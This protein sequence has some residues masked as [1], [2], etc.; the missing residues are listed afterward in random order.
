[1]KIVKKNILCSIGAILYYLFLK[2]LYLNYIHKF[3]DYSGFLYEGRQINPIISILLLLPAILFLSHASKKKEVSY[4]VVTVLIIIGFFPALVMA[5]FMRTEFFILLLVY[6]YFLMI[7]TV[8]IKTIRFKS[9]KFSGR[10]VERLLVC[11]FTS[12]TLYIWIRYAKM[13]I[14]TN[15]LDVYGQRALVS[16]FRYSRIISY[17]YSMSK[18]VIPFFIVYELDKKHYAY[19]F[20]L[21]I[22]GFLTFC[23]DGSK[24]ML[25]TI[26]IGVIAYFVIKK[27]QDYLWIFPY[28]LLLLGGVGILEYKFMSKLITISLFFRRVSFVPAQLNYDYYNYFSIREKDYFRGSLSLLGESPYDNISKIIGEFNG[29]GSS[30]N[31][32]LFSDAYLNFG[33]IG[34]IIFPIL[35]VLL[36]KC[37]DGAAYGI[38]NEVLFILIL[39]FSLSLISSAFFTNILSHGIFIMI[40]ILYLLKREKSTVCVKEKERLTG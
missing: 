3:W 37:L 35:I 16:S 39:K 19:S 20:I 11:I 38:K 29:S 8:V 2:H 13:H 33:G 24:G 21:W 31:N 18:L 25:F 32:G 12:V 1:M 34:V 22:I 17:I 14:Q 4:Q 30:C 27:I 6:Y 26:I 5:E 9:I 15:I 23:I 10:I 36:L 28:A 7:L 40:I